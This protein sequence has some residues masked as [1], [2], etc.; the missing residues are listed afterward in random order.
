MNNKRHESIIISTDQKSALIICF[1][2]FISLV[3]A[4]FFLM[5]YWLGKKEEGL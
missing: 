5:G 3:A 4:K 2:A 1:I